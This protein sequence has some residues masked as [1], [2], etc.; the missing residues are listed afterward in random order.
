MALVNG[1]EIVKVKSKILLSILRAIG[2]GSLEKLM[3]VVTY[4]RAM[5]FLR[6]QVF[7]GVFR[8]FGGCSGMFRDVPGSSV[9][10]FGVPGSTTCR[11]PQRW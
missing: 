1:F 7:L 5:C 2:G 6:F 11:R 3:R 10:C 9:P 4:W 8:A